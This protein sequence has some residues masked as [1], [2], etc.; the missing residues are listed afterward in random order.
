MSAMLPGQYDGPDAKQRNSKS[1]DTAYRGAREQ[2]QSLGGGTWGY[3][4]L[5]HVER[6]FYDVL[7]ELTEKYHAQV[8]HYGQAWSALTGEEI[9]EAVV[10]WLSP[11][12]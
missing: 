1:Y 3:G 11:A 7:V 9:E 12:R 8:R 2:L 10:L 6:D 5:I 4:P